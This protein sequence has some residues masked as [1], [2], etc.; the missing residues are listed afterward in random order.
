VQWLAIMLEALKHG[1]FAPPSPRS[2]LNYA[3]YPLTAMPYT[4]QLRRDQASA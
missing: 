1:D 3:S 4:K 2:D